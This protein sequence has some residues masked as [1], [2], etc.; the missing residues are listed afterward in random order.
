MS[1]KKYGNFILSVY[2]N[3]SWVSFMQSFTVIFPACNLTKSH[4]FL[5]FNTLLIPIRY[6]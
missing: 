4:L 5:Y 1:L 2:I 6:I 3:P